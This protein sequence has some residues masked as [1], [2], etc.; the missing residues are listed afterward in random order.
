MSP[1]P[2]PSP[3]PPCACARPPSLARSQKQFFRSGKQVLPRLSESTGSSSQHPTLPYSSGPSP[4]SNET[5]QT[6]GAQRIAY[7]RPQ[8][9]EL[10]LYS[11]LRTGVPEEM[12]FLCS[13]LY[14]LQSPEEGAHHRPSNCPRM[15][16]SGSPP[17][18]S[19]SRRS[20]VTEH[21]FLSP[22]LPSKSSGGKKG[23]E[24]LMWVPCFIRKSPASKRTVRPLS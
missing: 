23:R 11:A 19:W 6:S 17:P 12:N 16:S 10:P 13:V 24:C 20:S 4:S 1:S 9:D 18:I 22:G 8:S 15:L 2:S 14:C 5:R 21:F 7:R 3:S